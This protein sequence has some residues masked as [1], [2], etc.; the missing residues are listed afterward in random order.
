MR[1]EPSHQ[2]ARFDGLFLFNFRSKKCRKTKYCNNDTNKERYTSN[3]NWCYCFMQIFSYLI[4]EGKNPNEY[5]F[6][7]VSVCIVLVRMCVAMFWRRQCSNLACKQQ[8]L[9]DSTIQKVSIFLRK[10]TKK[11]REKNTPINTF[12]NTL[13]FAQLQCACEHAWRHHHFKKNVKM[14]SSIRVFYNISIFDLCFFS[15]I[16]FCS[17]EFNSL[18]A[19][20]DDWGDDANC[21]GAQPRPKQKQIHNQNE[22]M[23]NS[24]RFW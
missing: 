24:D 5:I 17:S 13:Y 22:T 10:N 19:I 14:F 11:R 23:P 21:G 2:V 16:F 4:T 8:N 1:V 3:G 18:V 20:V 15:L 12:R 6:A 7:S 9:A